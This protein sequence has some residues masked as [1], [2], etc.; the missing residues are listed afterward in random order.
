MQQTH[1]SAYYAGMDIVLVNPR[2]PQNTGSIAR[3]CAATQTQLHIIEPIPFEISEKT[4]RRAGLDYWPYVNITLHESFEKYQAQRA[5]G[6]VWLVT[7]FAKTT[8][9]TVQ[10]GP[11]DA[12]VFGNE[13]SG[14]PLELKEQYSNSLIR[15]P[16]ACSSV[17]SLNLSNAVSIVLFE[18]RRQLSLDL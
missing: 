4:V 8:Y 12:L 6:N 18:A 11:N 10:Y 13:E 9:T 5:P 7:K 16:M 1:K 3:T 15:I 14:L 17:R 2:I